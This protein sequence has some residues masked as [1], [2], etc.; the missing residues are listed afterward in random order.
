M[1]AH[2]LQRMGALSVWDAVARRAVLAF[3]GVLLL[4]LLVSAAFWAVRAA[5]RRSVAGAGAGGVG[6]GGRGVGLGFSGQRFREFDDEQE[7]ELMP[8]VSGG[9]SPNPNPTSITILQLPGSP[10]PGTPA[11]RVTIPGDL[12]SAR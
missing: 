1:S 7:Q 9:V 2:S 5:R 8:R 4:G 3:A 11:A 12:P 6:G 10:S